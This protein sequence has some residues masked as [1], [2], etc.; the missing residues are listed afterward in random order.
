MQYIDY[1]NYYYEYSAPVYTSPVASIASLAISVLLIVAM[2]MI[3]KKAGKPG[4]AAIVPFY[5][6]YTMYE[7]TWGSGWRFLMLL[8]PFYNIVL[9]I[10]TQIKLAKAFGKSG[11][12]AV[13]LIFLPYVFYPILAFDG[14]V[15]QGVPGKAGEGR[16]VQRE[17]YAP[18]SGS[19]RQNDYQKDTY[20]QPEDSGFRVTHCPNCGA[21]VDGGK[22]CENCGR[23]L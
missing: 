17:G 8:I 23:P 1:Y 7:I 2:W 14:S 12:F 5:N 19:Y 6:I 4:W 21:R 15:Y 3:F 16:R 10:Q 18:D 13:G 9:A 20:Q 22:F 11:G